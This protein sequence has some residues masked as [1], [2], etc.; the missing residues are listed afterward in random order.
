MK[1]I[2]IGG[3]PEHF[4]LPWTDVIETPGSPVD[5][6]VWVAQPQGTGAM[7]AALA[8]GD[9]DAA[10][11]LTEGAVTAQAAGGDFAIASVWVESP[12]LW[13]IHVPG[14]SAINAVESIRGRRVAISR[15]GSGSHLMALAHAREC[16]WAPDEHEFVVVGTIDGARTAFTEGRAEVFFWERYMTAPLVDTGEFRRVGVFE[17][18]WPAFVLC[19]SNRLD[20]NARARVTA[21]FTDVLNAARAFSDD[22]DAAVARLA[23]TFGIEPAAGRAWLQRTRWARRPG[24]DSRMLERVADVLVDAG[25][26]RTRP[27]P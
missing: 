26:I 4:N 25:V 5:D 3:V 13:G 12:L 9:L 7:V 2:S 16:G 22:V 11:L 19:V 1:K 23:E 15:F 21:V 18:P 14:A 17:A 27:R 24:L 8:D 6:V 20:G 10:L